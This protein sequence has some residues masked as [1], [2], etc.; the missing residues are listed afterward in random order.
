V[1]LVTGAT[2]NVGAEVARALVEAGEPVRAL[3]RDPSTAEL[4]AGVEAVRGD[5]DRPASLK[6]AL[7]GVSGVF[8][9]PG[10]QDMPGVVAAIRRAGV[11]RIVLLSSTA[12]ASGD[13]RNA[14]TAYML[15]SEAAVRA[16]A[17]T[18]T[19][20]RAY[21]LM[22]NTLRWIG[23]LE[24]GG[25]VREPFATVPV[26][27]V[28]PADIG[29]VAARALTS[30]AFAGETLALSGVGPIV[31]SD[32]VRILGTALGRPLRL[33]ALTNGE[34]RE[35]LGG[36]MPEEYVDAFFDYYV[37]GSL[38]ESQPTGDVERAIGRAPRT[39]AQWAEVHAEAF[40]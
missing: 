13:E 12:A 39:F 32:R 25:E 28:D 2:G 36:A 9:L 27:M 37:D 21:G 20:L 3:V 30:D 29:E 40:R 15:R 14:V 34:A 6:K 8:L 4:P 23:Q 26:A 22:S 31:A 16:F 10:Y 5:L 7:K 33:R 19:I 17:G 1:I 38:D 35:Q 11:T 18:W 24:V